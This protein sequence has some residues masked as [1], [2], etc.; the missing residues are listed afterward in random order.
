MSKAGHFL[1]DILES[2]KRVD[3]KILWFDKRNMDGM[4]ELPDGRT[5]EIRLAVHGSHAKKHADL[6]KGKKEG[7]TLSVELN[8]DLMDFGMVKVVK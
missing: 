4:V 3:A 1:K 5:F 8:P 6:M 7:D 2:D